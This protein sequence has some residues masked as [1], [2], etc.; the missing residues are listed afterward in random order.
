MYP[1]TRLHARGSAVLD[2]VATFSR[3]RVSAAAALEDKIRR[4]RT[5]AERAGSARDVRVCSDVLHRPL[6]P[7]EK[8]ANFA[9]LCRVRREER[10]VLS[11]NL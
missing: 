6:L 2:G 11:K 5:H 1:L 4:R 9:A 10:K 8:W 3:S 7:I